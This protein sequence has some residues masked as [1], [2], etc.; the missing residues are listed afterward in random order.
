MNIT[1][2]HVILDDTSPIVVISILSIMSSLQE[3][4]ARLREAAE[5]GNVDVIK[6]LGSSGVDV[7]N[8]DV[9]GKEVS[10]CYMLY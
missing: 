7:I 6:T 8:A 4:C 10:K 1:Y 3:E 9:S 2:D 5:N